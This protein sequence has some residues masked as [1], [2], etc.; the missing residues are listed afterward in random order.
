LKIFF[1]SYFQ[2]PKLISQY[3]IEIVTFQDP[4]TS[5]LGVYKIKKKYKD[6]K[7]VFES[8][9]DFINTLEL[10]EKSFIS[11]VY[12]KIYFLR[13]ASYTINCADMLR[14]VSSS[15]EEQALSFESI[16]EMLLGFLLGLILKYLAI[17]TLREIAMKGILKYSLLEA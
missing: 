6:V 2:I 4:V 8:H 17:S 11:K 5:F 15:T 9:G 16:K 10:R 1:V 7:I 13:M 14:A 12:I 3:E